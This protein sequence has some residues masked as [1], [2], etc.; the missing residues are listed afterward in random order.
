MKKKQLHFWW[1]STWILSLSALITKILSALYR[2]PLQNIVG[3]RGFFV[4]QQVYPIYGLWT[5]ITLTGLPMF[6]SQIMVEDPQHQ[7]SNYQHLRNWLVLLAIISAVILWLFAP[8]LA[9]LMGARQLS[10]LIQTV[11]GFYLLAPLAALFRGVFQGKL[12][13]LPTA[14][15]QVSEQI[16]RV[17]VIVLVALSFK[18]FHWSLYLMGS[19]AHAG[20]IVGAIA[21]LLV[22]GYFW[23]Q[24]KLNQAKGNSKALGWQDLRHRFLT[25]GLAL[26]LFGSLLILLQL[27][28][29]VTILK[30][31]RQIHVVHPQVVK[32][33]YDRGQPLAQL[34]IVIAVSFATTLLPQ[35]SAQRGQKSQRLVAATLHVALVL[36]S[37]CAV[38]LAVLMPQINTLLFTNAR[39]SLSL[40]IYVL[41][42]IFISYVTIINTIMHAFH[43]Q[44]KNWR[45]LV[46]GILVKLLANFGFIPR[47]GIQ[48]AS[49]ATL[50][51]SLVMAVLIY[52]YSGTFLQKVIWKDN[53]CLKVIVIVGTMGLIVGITS[54]CWQ[55]IWPLDRIH[56]A[57]ET[58]LEAG[59]GVILVLGGSY[60][61]HLWSKEEWQLLPGAK[62]L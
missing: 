43:Q 49:W 14:L 44:Q 47:L 38:G 26:S 18:Q 9:Q 19:L 41:S 12:L 28:D 31:L 39:Q 21:G 23:P 8:V 36:A 52:Y 51:A 56:A 61:S 53:F 59:L 4:Y 32:G 15:A 22:L 30:L 34:G 16:A 48:G 13:M 45:V 10:Y 6:I 7:Q 62:F 42:L 2:I 33:I 20:A 46:I 50:L 25:E 1:Q 54:W 3:D 37:A 57:I 24:I 35:I 17:L 27:I 40:A 55:F 29:S 5:A 58:L 11:A 60:Y